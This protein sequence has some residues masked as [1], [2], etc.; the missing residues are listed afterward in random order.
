MT[1]NND[2]DASQFHQLYYATVDADGNKSIGTGKELLEY[3]VI[4]SAIT[5]RMDARILEQQLINQYGGPNG[6]QLLNKI[7]SISPNQW[8][9]YGITP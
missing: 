7:N 1:G 5:N 3:E 2:I 9:R 8:S 4:E 6:G